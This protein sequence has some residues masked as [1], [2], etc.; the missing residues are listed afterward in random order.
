MNSTRK[1]CFI[2]G[3]IGSLVGAASELLQE[4]CGHL[5]LD[6]QTVAT[7]NCIPCRMPYITSMFMPREPGDRPPPV[8]PNTQN[9]AFIG[10]FVEIAL[11]MVFT[12]EFSVRAAQMAVYQLLGLTLPIPPVT[13][14]DQSLH[15]QF[16]A[17]VKTL[18]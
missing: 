7:A 12:V 5:R 2:G 4:L 6:L 10:Q 9:F 13:R 16:D 1:A 11:D 18:K 17:L 15:A 8:P 3:G 14:H